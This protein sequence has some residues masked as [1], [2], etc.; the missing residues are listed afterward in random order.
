MLFAQYENE[1][2]KSTGGM[3]NSVVSCCVYT[4]RPVSSGTLKFLQQN[5]WLTCPERLWLLQTWSTSSVILQLWILS[6]TNLHLHP[7]PLFS[8]SLPSSH[9]YKGKLICFIKVYTLGAISRLFC[10]TCMTAVLFR[11]QQTNSFYHKPTFSHII[12]S[13]PTT[14]SFCSHLSN[15]LATG[16]GGKWSALWELCSWCLKWR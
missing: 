3:V 14:T 5:P 13:P 10:L 4:R 16:A 8:P 1:A 7:S 15:N 11:C 12:R 9:D 6:L 2:I